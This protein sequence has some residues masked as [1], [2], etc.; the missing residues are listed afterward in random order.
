MFTL[1]YRFEAHRWVVV[2]LGDGE[3]TLALSPSLVFSDPLADLADI[4]VPLLVHLNDEYPLE[5]RC[6][7]EDEPGEYRWILKKESSDVQIQIL[8]FDQTY[9]HLSDEDG[10][11]IFIAIT[12]TMKFAIQVKTQMR[13]LL[14]AYGSH[15]YEEIARRPF[16]LSAYHELQRLIQ[17]ERTRIRQ[18]RKG[19]IKQP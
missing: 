9:S 6:A 8:R 4:T 11:Q 10:Q 2:N 19:E 3:Q 12:P 15:G 18:L 1:S 7:W 13:D 17:E 16:P 14:N 5:V